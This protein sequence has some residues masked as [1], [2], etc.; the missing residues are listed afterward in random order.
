MLQKL[1]DYR[2]RLAHKAICAVL[3]YYRA[4]FEPDPEVD[5]S[6]LGADELA[7]FAS[8]LLTTDPSH[9]FIFKGME[10][11]YDQVS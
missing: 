6:D 2:N 4:R 11:V 8:E 10:S 7:D 3:A 5:L 1:C 9:G